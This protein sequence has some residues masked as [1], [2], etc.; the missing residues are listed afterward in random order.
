[1]IVF[2]RHLISINLIMELILIYIFKVRTPQIINIC[3]MSSTI[4]WYYTKGFNKHSK[5]HTVIIHENTSHKSFY[6]WLS[7]QLIKSTNKYNQKRKDARK[8]EEMWKIFYIHF[9]LPH[10]ITDMG[11]PAFMQ[12]T[13][14][15]NF[16]SCPF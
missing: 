5:G 1:M 6:K 16:S 8:W 9:K 2:S 10:H 7:R 12:Y 11:I 4:K 14:T 13:E 3:R 15:Y